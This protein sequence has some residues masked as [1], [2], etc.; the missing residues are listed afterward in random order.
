MDFHWFG[1]STIAPSNNGLYWP[2]P[3]RTITHV[4]NK[5]PIT[6]DK[7]IGNIMH[8]VGLPSHRRCPGVESSA[9][10]VA[11]VQSQADAWTHGVGCIMDDVVKE[12]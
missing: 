4:K 8:N 5:Q 12:L 9:G 2:R 11:I 6:N 7:S 3:D 1:V 10:R